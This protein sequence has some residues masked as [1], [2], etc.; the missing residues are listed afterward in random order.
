MM[1]IACIGECMIEL[2]QAAGGTL[3]RGYGGDT[4][5]TATY[6]ARLGASVDYITALGDDAWSDEMV[7]GWQAEGIGTDHVVRIPGKLP[8]LYVIETS[9]SGERRFYY[10]RESSAARALLD[11][12]QTAAILAALS[13]YDVIYLSGITLSLYDAAGRS[14]LMAALAQA[15]RDGRRVAFDT[16]FRPRSWPDRALAQQ[17]YHAMF[18]IADIALASVEDLDL[19]FGEG[20][21]EAVAD[22]LEVPELVLKLNEPGSRVRA[23]GFDQMVTAAPVDRVVDTTA[24]GDSFS[25]AY[26]AARLAGADP[27]AAATA[28][29]RLAGVVVGYPGAIIPL[30]AMPKDILPA[31]PHRETAP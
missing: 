18:A 11:L 29:H 22:S 19:L 28:G 13:D 14:R 15:R 6:C 7:A 30:A 10:W 24:A 12:P 31:V 26:L 25:A 3:A 16:N 1:K 17:V 23:Q 5:N 20:K 8:G 9:A 21:G 2:T 27:V 4:L